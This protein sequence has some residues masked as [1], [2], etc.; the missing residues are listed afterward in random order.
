V[1]ERV[2]VREVTDDERQGL[3]WIVRRPSMGC[4]FD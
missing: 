3:L 2:Q 4:R 1:A